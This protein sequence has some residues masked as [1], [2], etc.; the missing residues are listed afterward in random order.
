MSTINGAQLKP[1]KT[2]NISRIWF[3][4]IGELISD[5][6]YVAERLGLSDSTTRQFN[7]YFSRYNK[8][9]ARLKKGCL[10]IYT[11]VVG[12]RQVFTSTTFQ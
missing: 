11:Y 1:T 5:R 8:V 10:I 7:R 4:K 12:E 3:R 6:P 2:F 9:C